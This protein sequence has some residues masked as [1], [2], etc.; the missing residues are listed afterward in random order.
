MEIVKQSNEHLQDVDMSYTEHCIF[1]LCLSL[2]FFL[3][4]I[5]AFCHALIPGV[6]TT[7][8]SDYS[9]LINTL[10]KHTRRDNVN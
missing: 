10:I 1:S 6:F 2:Q 7:S 4:A 8:S 3:A 9:E 5:F